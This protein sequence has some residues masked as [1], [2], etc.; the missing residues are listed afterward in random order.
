MEDGVAEGTVTDEV[1]K[2]VLD[3]A[4][5]AG[6]N[7]GL[8]KFVGA[9][10]TRAMEMIELNISR[11]WEILLLFQRRYADYG[12]VMRKLFPAGGSEIALMY[13][14]CL[15]GPD[16]DLDEAIGSFQCALRNDFRTTETDAP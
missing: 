3:F 16:E 10:I 5:E 7:W 6:G 15:N 11:D 13:S 14:R 4:V 1:L 9:T 12:T 2:R 8:E